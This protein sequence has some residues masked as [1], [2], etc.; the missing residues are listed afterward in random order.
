MGQRRGLIQS[1]KGDLGN[2]DLVRG[3]LRHERMRGGYPKHV[4]GIPAGYGGFPGMGG[5]PGRY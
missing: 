4:A 5:R 2:V 1:R 3:W